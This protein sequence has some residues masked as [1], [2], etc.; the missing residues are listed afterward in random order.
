MTRLFLFLALAL[1]LSAQDTGRAQ[2]MLARMDTLAS[3]GQKAGAISSGSYAVRELRAA[4]GDEA[5]ELG[6]AANRVAACCM[7]FQDYRAAL[8]FAELALK[9]ARANRERTPRDFV[10]SLQQF[11]AIQLALGDLKTARGNLEE[12]IALCHTPPRG[13]SSDA[14]PVALQLGALNQQEARYGEAQ[15]FFQLA[16]AI[17]E[18]VQRQPDLQAA[19]ALTSLARLYLRVGDHARAQ[20]IMQR[21]FL[22]TQNIVGPGHPRLADAL[23]SLGM[24]NSKAGDFSRADRAF[25]D[26]IAIR[27]RYM[28]GHP[29][30]AATLHL[31]AAHQARKGDIATAYELQG[32]AL[33]M[34]RRAGNPLWLRT[35][36]HSQAWFAMTT[37][38]YDE[39]AALLTEAAGMAPPKSREAAN[40]ITSQALLSSLQGDAESAISG[41]TTV[42]AIFDTVLAEANLDTEGSRLALQ[43]GIQGKTHFAVE[44]AVDI[45]P[46]S[47]PA[48]KLA[49]QTVLRRKGWTGEAMRLDRA[50]WRGRKSDTVSAIATLHA[51]IAHRALQAERDYD[52]EAARWLWTAERDLAA[53]A[54][55]LRNADSAHPAQV[56]TPE[57]VARRLPAESLLVEY[58]VY[59]KARDKLRQGSDADLPRYYAAFVLS[60]DGTLR[61]HALGPARPIENQLRQLRRALASPTSA[62]RRQATALAELILKPLNLPAASRL[63]IAPDGPLHLLPMGVLPDAQGEPLLA[64]REI[65]NLGSGRDLLTDTSGHSTE[66]PVLIAAPDYDARLANSAKRPPRTSLSFSPL[67]GAASEGKALK[68]LMPNFTLRLG[69]DAHEATLKAVRRPSI[70]HIATHGFYL[71]ASHALPPGLRG[72][73]CVKPPRQEKPLPDFALYD[74]P[75]VRA[76]LALAGA[77]HFAA[78]KEDGILSALEASNLDLTGTQC[79]VLSACQTGLGETVDGA[80]VLGLRRA[81]SEAGA[82]SMVLSLWKVHDEATSSL[83][84]SFYTH[85]GEGQRKSQALRQARLAIREQEK[86]AHPFYWAAF[87]YSGDNAAL[88][89]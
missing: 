66:A 73:Q 63:F 83:M 3:Q 43:Q 26:S 64:S 88:Q 22:I 1:P 60:P 45:A 42:H 31:M 34:L 57:A 65:I 21:A 10:A 53:H 14:A 67:P 84:Q 76:G 19:H 49:Y 13:Y 75:M 70:L 40:T 9:A 29:M 4:L 18:R 58:M 59:S 50:G 48:R 35:H 80:G 41:M 2:A 51:E 20:P 82:Q 44:L 5:P 68:A 23:D 17:H 6:M 24:L 11:G 71:N 78:G 15:H 56:A 25:S 69:A 27:E 47:E 61:A 7:R 8:P 79:V 12:A 32:R 36:L 30:Q 33:A 37:Q 77:N 46:E 89:D 54:R 38:R 39:A 86:W 87:V 72:L 16:I 74:S 55:E 28:P 52:R 62:Y 85:L 81:F